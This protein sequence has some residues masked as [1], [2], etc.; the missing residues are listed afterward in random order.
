MGLSPPLYA[1]FKNGFVYGYIQGQ[2][3]TVPDMSDTKKASLVARKI[4]TWHK[5]HLPGGEEA[6][7]FPTL[8]KWYGGIPTFYNVPETQAKFES[9]VDL[10]YLKSELHKLEAILKKLDSPVVFCHNDLLSGNII[11]EPD[12]GMKFDPLPH[13]Y[14]ENR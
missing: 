9:N 11:F 10:N 2:P 12:K 7:L 4:A 1:R 8:W 14:F 5:V 3:F 6:R 13:Y